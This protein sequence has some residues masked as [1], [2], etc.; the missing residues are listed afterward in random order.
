MVAT[1]TSIDTT[2]KPDVWYARL[3]DTPESGDIIER[4]E[5]DIEEFIS[6]LQMGQQLL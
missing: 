1:C 5:F 2:N 3:Q 6:L 4:L